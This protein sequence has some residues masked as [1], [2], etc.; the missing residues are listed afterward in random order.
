MHA[1]KGYANKNRALGSRTSIAAPSVLFKGLYH[2]LDTAC[3]C[4]LSSNSLLCRH[5]K[6]KRGSI[7]VQVKHLSPKHIQPYLL[8]MLTGMATCEQGRTA[9][10]GLL[11]ALHRVGSPWPAHLDWQVFDSCSLQS[12][13]YKPGFIAFVA[14]TLGKLTQSRNCRFQWGGILWTAVVR[15]RLF[16]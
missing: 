12:L 5:V 14:I 10:S 11:L 9:V 1:L 3:I 7:L 8:S 13:D 4:S 6:D 2:L 15:R 16:R